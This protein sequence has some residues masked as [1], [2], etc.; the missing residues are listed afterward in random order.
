MT[1]I[2]LKA[3]NELPEDNLSSVAFEAWQN[4]TISFLEQETFHYEFISGKYTEWKAKQDT[5]DGKRISRL[6]DQDP[7]KKVIE[8]KTGAAAEA[9]RPGELDNLLIKRN[10]QLTKFLQLIANLPLE[11]DK[12]DVQRPKLL[13]RLNPFRKKDR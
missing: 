7:E 8:A 13:S 9:A 10:A 6:D 12:D 2:K 5:A 11:A 1:T 3:P 4:Q